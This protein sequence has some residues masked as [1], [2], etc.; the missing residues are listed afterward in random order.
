MLYVS[1]LKMKEAA[2]P[3]EVIARRMQWEP[4]E[5]LNML[6]E[7]WVQSAD[8]VVVSV[9]ESDSNAA[10]WA[11]TAQWGDAFFID[12]HPAITAEQGLQLA[13]QMMP[14]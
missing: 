5:G 14:G 7:Y 8:A 6:S 3:Q 1:I 10:I 13:Q 12:V 2:N 11:M 4:P 9:F